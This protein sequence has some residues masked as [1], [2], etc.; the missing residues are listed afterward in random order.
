MRYFKIYHNNV[1]VPVGQTYGELS[2]IEFDA[3]LN[4]FAAENAS[5][6]EDEDGNIDFD[7]LEVEMG[8]I[9]NDVYEQAQSEDGFDYGDYHLYVRDDD[10]DKF[11][12]Y[13]V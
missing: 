5:D 2:E 9:A 3:E 10:F 11:D 12:I 8:E 7:A 13:R 4:N 6:H 1:R